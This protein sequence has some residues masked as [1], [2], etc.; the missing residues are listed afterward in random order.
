[1]NLPPVCIMSYR[2]LSFQ[3]LSKPRKPSARISSA[4][5][6]VVEE[7]KKMKY[8]QCEVACVPLAGGQ[9][10]LQSGRC[11]ARGG[12]AC[13]QQGCSVQC[14]VQGGG[15]RVRSGTPII[16]RPKVFGTHHNPSA[17]VW[18]SRRHDRQQVTD[19]SLQL[20][21]H[22]LTHGSKKRKRRIQHTHIEA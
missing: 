3:Y 14:A 9:Q 21:T 22:S 15:P 2:P 7:A 11:H 13:V 6:S 8:C 17:S 19:A 20:C 18:H 1:M 10:C 16:S 12:S 5:S 4:G